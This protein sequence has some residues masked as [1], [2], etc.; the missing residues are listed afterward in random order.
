[1]FTRACL[2]PHV[3]FCNKLVFLPRVVGHL[4]CPQDGKLHLVSCLQLLIQCTCSYPPYLEAISICS[5]GTHHAVVMDMVQFGI[6]KT[7][8]VT[9]KQLIYSV[10]VVYPKVCGLSH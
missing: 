10:T 4:P 2:R 7:L 3:M 9:D 6:I 5:P 8:E 1:M